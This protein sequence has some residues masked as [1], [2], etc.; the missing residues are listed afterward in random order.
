MVVRREAFEPLTAPY[1]S[2]ALLN[3]D[4]TSHKSVASSVYWLKY[5]RAQ[6]PGA[7]HIEED[8]PMKFIRA[9]VSDQPPNRSAV[10]R[11]PSLMLQ[12]EI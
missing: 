12:N 1:H 11:S 5:G 8:G 3:E 9:S 10:G 2:G 6:S 4:S 7:E